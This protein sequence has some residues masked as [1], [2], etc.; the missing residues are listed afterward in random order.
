MDKERKRYWVIR[1]LDSHGT[2]LR[3]DNKILF[4]ATPDEARRHISQKC[5]DSPYLTI[6]I[7][8]HK[9]KIDTVV[10]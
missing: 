9:K 10:Q 7:W 4:F 6:K 2:L 5:G 1:T 8:R 3:K